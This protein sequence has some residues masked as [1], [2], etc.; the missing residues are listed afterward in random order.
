M[1]V[2]HVGLMNKLKNPL[3][4]QFI[5][6]IQSYITGRM[7]WVKQE[8]AYPAVKEI[9]AGVPQGS[10]LGPILYL[11]YTWDIP[12]E[13]DITTATFA[14]YTAIL[15]VGY[16]SEETTTKLQDA[17]IRINDWTRLWRTSQY[18]LTLLTGRMYRSR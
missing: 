1:Y 6:I 8:E 5:Q 9:K 13:E 14:V 15:A 7:F 10:V 4:R 2:W 16:S 18:I 17:C 12:Q 11:L 3:P